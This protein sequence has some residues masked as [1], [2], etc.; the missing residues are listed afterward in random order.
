[1]R[2]FFSSSGGIGVDRG[3]GTRPAGGAMPAWLRCGR[4]KKVVGWSVRVG[5]AGR[6]AQAQWGGGG[7]EKGPV[8]KNKKWAAAGPKVT[9]KFFSE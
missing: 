1:M 9:G 6:E 5:W 3:G 2:P 7:G 4:K 8:E